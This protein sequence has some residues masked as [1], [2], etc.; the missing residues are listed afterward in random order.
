MTIT[1]NILEVFNWNELTQ[2]YLSRTITVLNFWKE[3]WPFQDGGL[4]HRNQSIDLLCKSVDWLLYDRSPGHEKVKVVVN[5]VKGFG[6]HETQTYMILLNPETL[7]K[8]DL[9]EKK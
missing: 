4:C 2:M 8:T 3:N 5:K 1:P 6:L 7:L 9:K